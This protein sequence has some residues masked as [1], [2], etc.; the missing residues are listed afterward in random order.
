MILQTPSVNWRFL[1]AK[2][3]FQTSMLSFSPWKLDFPNPGALRSSEHKLLEGYKYKEL[4]P[5]PQLSTCSH[6]PCLIQLTHIFPQPKSNPR[7]ATC[8]SAPSSGYSRWLQFL[9]D[10]PVA[11]VLWATCRVH[12]PTHH[13]GQALASR[14]SR[15]HWLHTPTYCHQRYAWVGCDERPEVLPATVKRLHK[16]FNLKKTTK[17]T[18]RT[19]PKLL[20]GFV[21]QFCLFKHTPCW[22]LKTAALFRS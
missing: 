14:P 19:G 8:F 1:V 20:Q 4:L 5:S 6:T 12:P 9:T 21:F 16:W 13:R 7:P 11:S 15:R 22:G 17:K 2:G 10:T 18:P 3:H